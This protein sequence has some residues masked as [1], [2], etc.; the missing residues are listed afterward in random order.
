[1]SNFWILLINNTKYLLCM[2]VYISKIKIQPVKLFLLF[3]N[4]YCS[5]FTTPNQNL[6]EKKHSILAYDAHSHRIPNICR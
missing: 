5:N 3:A 4:F 6:Y 1:M 2:V